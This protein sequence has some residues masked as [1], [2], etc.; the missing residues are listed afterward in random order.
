MNAKDGEERSGNRMRAF[1]SLA[2]LSVVGL[3]CMPASASAQGQRFTDTVTGSCVFSYGAAH[4][5]RQ[6]RYNDSG[7]SG[8]KHYV[9]PVEEIAEAREREKVWEARCRPTLRQDYYGVNRYVYAAPGCEYGR[10]R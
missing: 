3:A 9:E 2:A 8:I 6:Y 7:N 4:C 10:L 1:V 5:V